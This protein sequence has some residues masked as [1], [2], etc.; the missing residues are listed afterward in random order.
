[1]Q[2]L[3]TKMGASFKRAADSLDDFAKRKSRILAI[4]NGSQRYRIP[5]A[6]ATLREGSLRALWTEKA[7]KGENVKKVRRKNRFVGGK[8]PCV[9]L[10]C[11][12]TFHLR[13]SLNLTHHPPADQSAEIITEL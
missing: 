6:Q 1:M 10:L 7:K 9:R 2:E 11:M 3:E 5:G 4:Q 13:A 8:V 12:H